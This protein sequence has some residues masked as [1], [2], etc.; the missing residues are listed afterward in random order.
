MPF[1]SGSFFVSS[2][3]SFASSAGASAARV[4][5]LHFLRQVAQLAVGVDEAGLF[6]AGGTVAYEF[7]VVS[8]VSMNAKSGR[9]RPARSMQ[10][11]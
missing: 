7:H 4:D 11:F 2:F 1:T 3:S 10:K 5:V 9:L 6:L 8:L